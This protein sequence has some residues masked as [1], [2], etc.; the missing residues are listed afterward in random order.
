MT[1]KPTLPLLA[2]TRIEETGDLLRALFAR[3]AEE[4]H[5]LI[6]IAQEVLAQP[7][8]DFEPSQPK[9]GKVVNLAEVR[10]G[11]E[12][13]Q[14]EVTYEDLKAAERMSDEQLADLLRSEIAALEALEEEGR[15]ALSSHKKWHLVFE[16]NTMIMRGFLILLTESAKRPYLE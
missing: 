12:P 1:Q 8:D 3:H 10:R 5:S 2:G 15:R 7:H 14:F 13:A 6:T 9:K 4:Y 11:R 16:A